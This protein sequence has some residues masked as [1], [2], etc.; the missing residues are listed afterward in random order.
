MDESELRAY[1]KQSFRVFDHDKDGEIVFQE[2]ESTIQRLSDKELSLLKSGVA[3]NELSYTVEDN[4]DATI[5]SS[6]AN[7]FAVTAEV[8]ISKIAPAGP[9][10]A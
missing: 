8:A 7:R 10:T 6:L 4:A 3:R 5:L 9:R 1:G 2:F